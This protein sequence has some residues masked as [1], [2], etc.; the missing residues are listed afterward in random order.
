MSF[1]LKTCCLIEHLYMHIL[2]AIDLAVNLKYLGTLYVH[3]VIGQIFCY[4]VVREWQ[5]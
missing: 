2:K 1:S 4:I 5:D 3:P